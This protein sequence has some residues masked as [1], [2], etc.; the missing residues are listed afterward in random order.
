VPSTPLNSGHDLSRFLEAVSA[1]ILFPTYPLLLFA[2]LR[3]LT[4]PFSRSQAAERGHSWI[5]ERVALVRRAVRSRCCC[6]LFLKNKNG[7]LLIP[8]GGGLMALGRPMQSSWSASPG[9]Y[10]SVASAASLS[11]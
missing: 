2:S 10:P 4:L 1:P 5:A 11:T 9:V 7:P 3:S 8:A 6:S